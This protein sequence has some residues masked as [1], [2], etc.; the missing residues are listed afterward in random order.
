MQHAQQGCPR[1]PLS[2]SIN[3]SHAIARTDANYRK[4][5]ILGIGGL[6]AGL[7]RQDPS[8]SSSGELQLY[9][10]GVAMVVCYRS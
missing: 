9:K 2:I 6:P 3:S 5:T 7:G 4:E 10:L 1:G 8:P